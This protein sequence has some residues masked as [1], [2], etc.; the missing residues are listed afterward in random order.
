MFS[1]V[2]NLGGRRTA[3]GYKSD[4][5]PAGS[6]IRPQVGY[7]HRDPIVRESNREP[8]FF[9]LAVRRVGESENSRIIKDRRCQLERDTVFA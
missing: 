1:V 2:A 8:A 5:D 9:R 7:R 6:S 4:L 3:G